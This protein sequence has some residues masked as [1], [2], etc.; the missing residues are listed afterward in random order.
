MLV[1][2]IRDIIVSAEARVPQKDAIRYKKSKNKIEN[3]TYTQLK[4]DSE[5]FSA[6]LK[7]LGE[8]FYN[9]WC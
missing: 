1:S 5:R 9:G 7:T 6:V 2:T 4:A 8:H 3:K